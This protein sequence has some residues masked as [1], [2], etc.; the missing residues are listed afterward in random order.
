MMRDRG[1]RYIETDCHS[2]ADGTVIVFHDP[3][4]DRVTEA[5]GKISDWT[6]SDLKDVKDHSGNRIVLLDEL[7]E[8]FPDIVFNLDAK[9]NGV[10]KPMAQT[11]IRHNALERVSLASFSE[12]RLAYMR[13]KL[14]GVRSSM[15]TSA[16]GRLVVAANGPTVIR[17]AALHRLPGPER[18]VEA[19]QVPEFFKNIEI[20]N[21]AFIGLAH[22]R[23]LAV[24]VWTVNEEPDMV[25]LLD[26]GVDGLITDE[27]TLAQNV[28]EEKFGCR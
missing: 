16:I 7:L 21:E 25:K 23:G 10:A 11:I 20:I 4:L 17:R 19:V 14:P 28:I 6:W 18:G 1:F 26:L 9:H 15:G 2:T 3:I 22:A 24:H 13:R 12:T 27:P 5:A 8:E